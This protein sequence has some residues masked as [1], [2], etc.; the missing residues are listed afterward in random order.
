[1]KVLRKV[2]GALVFVAGWGLAAWVGVYL[3]FV[4][5]ITDIVN[6]AEAHPVAGSKLAWGIFLVAVIWEFA[7]FGIGIA[8]SLLAGLIGFETP[9]HRHKRLRRERLVARGRALGAP[10]GQMEG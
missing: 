6:A 2:I 8:L 4:G 1:M 5:G 3:C 10:L 9:G 7:L